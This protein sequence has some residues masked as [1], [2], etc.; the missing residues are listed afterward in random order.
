VQ[1]EQGL[2]GRY[3]PASAAKAILRA[4]EGEEH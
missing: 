1:I 4:F 2:P 3:F